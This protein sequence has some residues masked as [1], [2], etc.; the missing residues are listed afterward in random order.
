[1]IHHG[2]QKV[3]G[4]AFCFFGTLASVAREEILFAGISLTTI[5]SRETFK[6][7]DE[8]PYSADHCIIGNLFI[9]L[10]PLYSGSSYLAV[11]T[12]SGVNQ[13]KFMSGP[14][15]RIFYHSAGYIQAV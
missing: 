3:I 13:T 12:L 7:P 5:R 8:S 14:N 11:V 2:H 6:G 9:G 1:M 15:P 4:F 10:I